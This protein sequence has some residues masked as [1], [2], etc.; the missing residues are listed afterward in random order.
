[1]DFAYSF[2]LNKI[3][4]AWVYKRLSR[5]KVAFDDK[6]IILRSSDF[7]LKFYDIQRRKFIAECNIDHIYN[8]SVVGQELIVQSNWSYKKID[9]PFSQ[10][11][12]QG[13]FHFYDAIDSVFPNPF[14]SINDFLPKKRSDVI[15]EF[16]VYP[17]YWSG[18]HHTTMI[19]EEGRLQ[20]IFKENM[21]FF[22]DI[23]NENIF[24]LA[25]LRNNIKITLGV[26]QH[27][28]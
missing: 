19:L 27:L 15:A 10:K 26:M 4:D 23:Y 9:L 3:T 6:I 16:A 11:A 24:T 22:N 14:T 17:I 18:S 7:K 25:I 12:R 21:L 8:F 2:N 20:Q 1:M 13:D 28:S 5:P